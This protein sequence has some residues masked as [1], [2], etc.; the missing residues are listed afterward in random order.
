MKAL[1]VI[2]AMG[3]VLAIQ[4]AC[5]V[6]AQK[7]PVARAE[8]KPQTKPAK[9]SDGTMDKAGYSVKSGWNSFTKSVKQGRKKPACTQEQ[10]SL[11]QC[12]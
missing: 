1:L 9:K 6:D 12:Q 5:A 3:L 8:Q 2:A 10:K 11:K 4:P 7:Q